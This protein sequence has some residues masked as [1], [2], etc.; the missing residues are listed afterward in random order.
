MSLNYTA[1]LPA[2]PIGRSRLIE[3]RFS[4][5]FLL[6]FFFSL[7]LLCASAL[8]ND[9]DCV[10]GTMSYIFNRTFHEFNEFRRNLGQD[11]TFC[12]INH[13]R[14]SSVEI[15][16]SSEGKIPARNTSRRCTKSCNIKW[17]WLTLL[18]KFLDTVKWR[19]GHTC[20]SYSQEQVQRREGRAFSRKIF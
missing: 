6:S 7:S 2:K 14:T 8:L 13:D 17:V 10:V 20:Y 11:D 5:D 1:T 15:G 16:D 18:H 19:K 3:I 9:G 4:P 12:V